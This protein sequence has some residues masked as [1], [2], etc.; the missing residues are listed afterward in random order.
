MTWGPLWVNE[1]LSAELQLP[2]GGAL[3]LETLLVSRSS[4]IV[5]ALGILF[6]KMILRKIRD[7]RLL[8]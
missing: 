2:A 1:S 3:Q 8:G 5:L 7:I 6:L 4:S